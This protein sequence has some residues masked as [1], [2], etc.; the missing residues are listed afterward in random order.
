MV[1][2]GQ[3]GQGLIVISKKPKTKKPKLK[4]LC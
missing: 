2:R 1:N 4:D 3:F